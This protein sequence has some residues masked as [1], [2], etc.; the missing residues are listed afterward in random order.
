ML[1]DYQA[2][3]SLCFYSTC[4]PRITYMTQ[5]RTSFVIQF[6]KTKIGNDFC[7][8]K[9]YFYNLTNNRYLNAY[10]ASCL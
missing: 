4:K 1:Y 6:S 7:E 9:N 10:N 2:C 5:N 3:T 8:V